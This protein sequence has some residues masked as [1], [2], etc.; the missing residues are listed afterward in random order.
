MYTISVDG[1]APKHAYHVAETVQTGHIPES[2]IN[3][4]GFYG[5]GAIFVIVS[6]IDPS[7][8]IYFPLTVWAYIPI[9]FTLTYKLSS[10]YRIAGG[11]VLLQYLTGL[12]G[13]EKLY[14][15]PHGFGKML[16][17]TVLI[18]LIVSVR[19]GRWYRRLS[20]CLVIILT[21]LMFVSYNLSVIALACLGILAISTNL[22]ESCANK[23]SKYWFSYSTSKS[24]I[25]S[26]SLAAIVIFGMSSFIYSTAIPLVLRLEEFSTLSKFTSAWFGT[27]DLPEELAAIYFTRPPTLTYLAVF[28]YVIVLFI[29][30]LLGI[31]I[32]QFL[33]HRDLYA[34]DLIMGSLTLSVGIFMFL[35]IFVG[36]I[37]VQWLHLPMILTIGYLWKNRDRESA[38]LDIKTRRSIVVVAL[39]LLLIQA[40]IFYAVGLQ[41]NSINRVDGFS[42]YE[43]SSEFMS[44]YSNKPVL[45][46][47]TSQYLV[48]SYALQSYKESQSGIQVGVLTI[49]DINKMRTQQQVKEGIYVTYTGW[50]YVA[51][52]NWVTVQSWEMSEGKI[53]RNTNMIHIY[54]SGKMKLYGNN[55]MSTKSG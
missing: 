52:P 19:N 11:V 41:S 46:T 33:R 7:A 39:V 37:P 44:D 1:F 18:L 51:L 43:E 12:E 2:G 49:S 17:F 38:V 6:N 40:P 55:N 25:I 48:E 26:I 32:L 42:E 45:T 5:F 14:F 24:L 34:D 28:K 3:V 31:L 8:L 21:S 29:L 20:L 4:E 35:R 23:T 10:D 54:D 50:N 15:W 36:A 9:L 16:F 13:T 47:K 30:S 22:L 27:N 53:Q